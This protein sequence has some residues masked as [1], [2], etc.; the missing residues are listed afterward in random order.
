VNDP[1]RVVFNSP[2][3]RPEEN[4]NAEEKEA[5]EREG[6]MKVDLRAIWPLGIWFGLD[7]VLELHYR[8]K[9]CAL[10]G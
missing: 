9:N 10:L 3:Q 4:V 1:E 7:A 8:L 6:G 2:R 5:G